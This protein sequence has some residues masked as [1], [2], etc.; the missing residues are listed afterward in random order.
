MAGGVF[1]TQNK[2]R[3]G[4]YH[5]FTRAARE[6]GLFS[7]IGVA[8]LPLELDWG[9]AEA[10]VSIDADATQSEAMRKLGHNMQD[11]L[12]VRECLKRAQTLR[13]YRVNT[14]GGVK[15]TL[16][17]SPQPVTATAKY[18]GELG[19]EIRVQIDDDP[20]DPT[21]YIVRTY[22]NAIEMDSQSN[23]QNAEDIKGND[24]VDFA[25]TGAITAAAGGSLV[26]GLNGATTADTHNKF[27]KALETEE[28]NSFGLPVD[29]PT[30]KEMYAA[31]V[32]HYANDLGKLVQCILPNYDSTSY[33]GITSMKNGVILTDGT[34]ITAEQSVAWMT[35]ASAAA[36]AGTSLTYSAYDGAL[37][38]D[39]ILSDDE[40]KA[41]I[42]AGQIVFIPQTDDQ[43]QRIA[44]VEQDIN[45]MTR[46]T[47][48]RPE[49][50]K[51]N[52]MVRS[53][54]YS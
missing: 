1:I 29:D 53:I 9:D 51:K 17:M 19:N 7:P 40:I 15:A 11:V 24:W 25:G 8:A 41:A 16:D 4:F 35:G 21:K 12:L 37:Q 6:R 5:R 22:L 42:A 38:P 43:G 30:Y 36:G 2:I 28:F 23:I 13:F 26:G 44:V 31:A 27:L 34:T 20:N 46:I 50:W 18:V 33:E 48:D 32:I 49:E 10:I 52:R 14:D 3:P 54:Y 47:D 45:T 39:T